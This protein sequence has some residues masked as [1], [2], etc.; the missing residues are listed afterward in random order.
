M[1]KILWTFFD[2]TIITLGTSD[3]NLTPIINLN[4]KKLFA[5]L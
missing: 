4:Q 2:P 3:F 5:L 1:N